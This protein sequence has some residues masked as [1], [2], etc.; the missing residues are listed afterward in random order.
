[1]SALLG[2]HGTHRH[3]PVGGQI[4]RVLGPGAEEL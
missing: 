2:L 1:V 4:A 3:A